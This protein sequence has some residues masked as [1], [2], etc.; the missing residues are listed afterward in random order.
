MTIKILLF[1]NNINVLK[2]IRVTSPNS[3][4]FQPWLMKSQLSIFF[5]NL[6][7]CA[8]YSLCWTLYCKPEIFLWRKS[9]SHIPSTGNVL[10]VF[11]IKENA[12]EC[13]LWL[14][15]QN[16]R[17]NMFLWNGIFWMKIKEMRGIPTG[18]QYNWTVIFSKHNADASD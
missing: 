3:S 12:M 8:V 18:T 15:F 16:Q 17:N 13:V 6:S 11:K 2:N 9:L 7:L 14:H 4:H 10:S 1:K 5:F